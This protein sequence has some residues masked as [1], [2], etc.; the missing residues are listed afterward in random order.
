MGYTLGNIKHSPV[1]DK[2]SLIVTSDFGYRSFY[3]NGKQ[4]SGIHNGID[5]VPVG[6][7]VAVA[8]GK[9][10]ACRNNI[11]GYTESQASGNYVT[12]YH[13][14]GIYTTYCHL[15]YNSVRVSVGQIVETG[16]V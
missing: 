10:T 12:L 8:R 2:N 7:V 3:Y 16:T 14:N 4:H 9:V 6:E 13:G 15:D 5:L 11:T 1:K